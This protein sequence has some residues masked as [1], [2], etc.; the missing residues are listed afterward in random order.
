MEAL[1]EARESLK[2][3]EK[4]EIAV[5]KDKIVNI[6]AE[7]DKKKAETIQDIY[8]ELSLVEKKIGTVIEENEDTLQLFEYFPDIWACA[9]MES[10]VEACLKDME[11]LQSKGILTFRRIG[12]LSATLEKKVQQSPGYGKKGP[13]ITKIQSMLLDPDWNPFEIQK[14]ENCP[15]LIIK[16]E[17][18][19]YKELVEAYGESVA[20]GI[21]SEKK[22]MVELESSSGFIE[23]RIW[24]V[25]HGRPM[26]GSEIAFALIEYYL[27]NKHKLK[28]KPE[29]RRRN[30][31]SG[32]RSS[33]ARR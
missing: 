25:E 24:N 29:P 8:S 26:F 31:R 23:T 22:I 9:P 17:D 7:A 20:D 16:S 5:M 19:F 3:R 1:N 18:P 28:R 30:T 15:D 32:L 11:T 33:G 13:S 6:E 10:L 4:S 2:E 14:G 12:E 21:A 27:A